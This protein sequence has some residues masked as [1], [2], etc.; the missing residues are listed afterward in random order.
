M[1]KEIKKEA[2]KLFSEFGMTMSTAVNVF[3][4]QAVRQR[5]LPFEITAEATSKPHPVSGLGKGK[6]WMADDFD[7]PLEEMKEYME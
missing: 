4:R 5:K 1:D 2:E 6:I 3:V 7:A